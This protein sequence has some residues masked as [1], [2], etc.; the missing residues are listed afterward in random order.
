MNVKQAKE[1]PVEKV[2]ERMGYLPQKISGYDLFFLS[3]F[4][5]EKTPSFHLNTKKNK[6]RCN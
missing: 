6:W 4:R 3:P 1:I 5:L 2:L